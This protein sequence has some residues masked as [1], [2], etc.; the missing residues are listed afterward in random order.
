MEHMNLILDGIILVFLAGTIFYAM[1]LSGHLKAFRDTRA[2][3]DQ[4]IGSLTTQIAKAEKSVTVMKDTAQSSG[5]ALQKHIREAK[6]L[7]DELDMMIQ[8]G[9]NMADRMEKAAM[10]GKGE[11]PENQSS[12]PSLNAMADE[13]DQALRGS[14]SSGE[15]GFMI[16]DREYDD[17]EDLSDSADEQGLL[18]GEGDD[19]PSP[20]TFHSRAERELFEAM[21]SGGKGPNK[22]TKAGG[23]S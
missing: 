2:E 8:A 10:R 1:K 11:Q 6:M 9:N 15:T 4:L 13:V 22:R 17:D 21:T 19:T 16:H 23:V 5:E 14:A 3:L 18:P 20:D 12:A 7:S